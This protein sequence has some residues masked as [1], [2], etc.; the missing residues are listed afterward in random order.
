M[1]DDD[2]GHLLCEIIGGPCSL[3]TGR[4][5]GCTPGLTSKTVTPQV[6]DEVKALL[7]KIDPDPERRDEYVRAAAVR[8]A[9]IIRR[10]AR[11]DRLLLVHARADEP[12][13][14]PALE[15]LCVRRR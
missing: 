14:V 5:R 6:F 15:R 10:E 8:L 3:A 13:L 9:E 11:E 4:S 1:A 12:D 2:C 7:V